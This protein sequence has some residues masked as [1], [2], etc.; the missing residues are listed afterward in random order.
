MA[1][2]QRYRIRKRASGRRG[3]VVNNFMNI[4]SSHPEKSAI[5]MTD[6]GLFHGCKI[7]NFEVCGQA[8]GQTVECGLEACG[9]GVRSGVRLGLRCAVEISFSEFSINYHDDESPTAHLTARQTAHL[10]ARL[11]ASNDADR[12]PPH[13]SYAHTWGRAHGRTCRHARR[14]AGAL[15]RRRARAIHPLAHFQK[16]KG[17]Y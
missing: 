4:S 7:G 5:P 2:R 11:K 8:C 14:R 17:W 3:R 16:I 1:D 13:A 9:S 6:F 15:A 12:T 10:T